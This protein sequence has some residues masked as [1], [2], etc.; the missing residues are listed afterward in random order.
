MKIVHHA[1][2]VEMKVRQLII[3]GKTED[4]VLVL[5]SDISGESFGGGI[6]QE[7]L[8]ARVNTFMKVPYTMEDLEISLQIL[9]DKKAITDIPRERKHTDNK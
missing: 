1:S 9:R 5:M 6:N 2:E 8:L 4:A 7:K 3:E